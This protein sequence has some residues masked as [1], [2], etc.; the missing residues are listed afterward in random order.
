MRRRTFLQLAASAA[1]SLP[2]SGLQAAAGGRRPQPAFGR[3]ATEE[4]LSACGVSMHLTSLTAPGV[5][6]FDADTATELA[7]L[8]NDLQAEASARHPT[9]LAGL[10]S[11]APHSL[12]SGMESPELPDEHKPATYHRNAERVSGISAA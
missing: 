5:Q 12:T 6:M 11:F 2:P 8:A 1:A 7:A 10:A 3:I 9:R 4:A